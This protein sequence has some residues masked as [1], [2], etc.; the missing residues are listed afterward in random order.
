MLSSGLLSCV[1]LR[2]SSRAMF[3]TGKFGHVS[4]VTS[5]YGRVRY[6]LVRWGALWLR[7]LRLGGVRYVKFG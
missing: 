2:R 6:V 4:A 5:G 7:R 1:R 3:R